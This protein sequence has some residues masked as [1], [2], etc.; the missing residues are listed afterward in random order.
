M[1]YIL[2]NYNDLGFVLLCVSF[3]NI[4]ADAEGSRDI[5][6]ARVAVVSIRKVFNNSQKNSRWQAEMESRRNEIISELE[7]ISKELKAI[8]A[9]IETRKKESADGYWRYRNK[10]TVKNLVKDFIVKPCVAD[11]I[12]YDFKQEVL[13]RNRLY[14]GVYFAII[15]KLTMDIYYLWEANKKDD[16]WNDVNALATKLKYSF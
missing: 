8:Q 6:P 1:G 13:N 12:F 10:F 15:K 2:L 4:R 14:A 3:Q 9:D 7:Q 11:E 5:L 16:S